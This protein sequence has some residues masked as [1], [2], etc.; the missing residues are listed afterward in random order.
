MPGVRVFFHFLLL[1]VA[2]ATAGCR[3]EGD[4][5]IASLRFNGVTQVD[6]A[7]LTSA[8]QTKAGSRIPWG[9]RTRPSTSAT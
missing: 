7:A 3:E 4:I 2:I 8:L 1:L 9:P 5:R 6:K